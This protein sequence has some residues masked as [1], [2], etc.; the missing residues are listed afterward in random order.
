[1]KKYIKPAIEVENITVDSSIMSISDQKGEYSGQPLKS[2][3]F[4][5]EEE[6]DDEEEW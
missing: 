6:A 4:D 1:M 2:K 3:L 5:F